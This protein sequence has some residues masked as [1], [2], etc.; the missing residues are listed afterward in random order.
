[1]KLH[2]DLPAFDVYIR[3]DNDH[4]GA[5]WEHSM[6]MHEFSSCLP[7]VPP[8]LVYGDADSS[9]QPDTCKSTTGVLVLWHI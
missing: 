2:G 1:M 8:L 9:M 6:D 5:E 4:L 7:N 3:W